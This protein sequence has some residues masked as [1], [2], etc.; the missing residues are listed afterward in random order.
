MLVVGL[1]FGLI[2]VLVSVIVLV[3]NNICETKGRQV[4]DFGDN[5]SRRFVAT[6]Q[7]SLCHYRPLA[8]PDCRGFW[9][10]HFRSTRMCCLWGFCPCALAICTPAQRVDC[11]GPRR[12]KWGHRASDG[13]IS[14]SARSVDGHSPWREGLQKDAS[15]DPG[16]RRGANM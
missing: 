7:G 9:K 4:P 1:A 3:Y 6:R 12:P 13:R 8:A 15:A 5:R 11:F 14:R 2:L 16:N 10:E